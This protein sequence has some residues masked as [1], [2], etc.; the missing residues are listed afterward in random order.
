V[1]HFIDAQSEG[2]ESVARLLRR[3]E[4][5]I[6][7]DLM[8]LTGNNRSMIFARRPAPIQINYL[9]YAGTMGADYID[10]IVADPIVIP[11]DNFEFFQEKIVW[12]PGSFIP[13]DPD[14][15]VAGGT[16]RRSDCGLP[17]Q[18]FVFCC[19]N[20]SYKLNPEIF[21]CWMRLLKA[22]PA[23]V[24]WLSRQGAIATANLRREAAANGVSPDR[25]VFTARVPSVTDHLARHRLADLFLDTLPYNAHS[26]ANDALLAGLPVLT[27]T[28]QTFAGRVAASLLSAVGLP[29][30]IVDSEEA[31]E[32]AALQL[33]NDPA[34]S[35]KIRQK[36]EANR[37]TGT[38]FNTQLFTRRLE[39]AYTT[40][41]E[42][43]R[44]HLPPD[45][46]AVT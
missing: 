18:A 26:T 37:L 1:E 36:L 7:V 10:Y 6:A 33:A 38:L 19:F 31:Y 2:D 44:A 11:R 9:G 22:A 20:N 27:R 15:D 24:L 13:N 46:F 39:A 28:G 8:G 3:L 41:H 17:E 43:H 42:R 29:E 45:H 35:R 21:R 34:K 30:L 4:I 16:S 5:D 23:S 14:R 12:L 32:N 40:M 25:L